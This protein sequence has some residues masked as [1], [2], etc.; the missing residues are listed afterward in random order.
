MQSIIV[1]MA[2]EA[3]APSLVYFLSQAYIDSQFVLPLSQRRLSIADRVLRPPRPTTWFVATQKDVIV[4]CRGIIDQRPDARTTTFVVDPALHGTGIG[5]Q[6][7]C[8][9]I[10]FVIDQ[11]E[12]ERLRTDS[13][14]GNLIIPKL[15]EK[16]GFREICRY[17]DTAR[18]PPGVRTIE[19]EIDLRFPDAK[20]ALHDLVCVGAASIGG[21]NE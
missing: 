1:R 6:L 17:F 10:R 5:T 9:S 19:Y 4:G 16:F 8:E 15:M 11:L 7:F 12:A 2:D 20:K 18:R 13:W 14:E 21:G 3:L